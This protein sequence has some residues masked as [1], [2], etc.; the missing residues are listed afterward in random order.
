MLWYCS[1]TNE[2]M[3]IQT[4]KRFSNSCFPAVLLLT[5]Q[6]PTVFSFGKT[7]SVMT[8][9]SAIV[10]IML[11]QVPRM[12]SVHKHHLLGKDQLPL[13][14]LVHLFA[15]TVGCKPGAGLFGQQGLFKWERFLSMSRGCE[16]SARSWAAPRR[17]GANTVTQAEPR[18][19]EHWP[20]GLLV[21]LRQSAWY[22]LGQPDFLFPKHSRL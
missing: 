15:V 1:L 20:A 22:T 16:L 21:R 6:L 2:L 17:A 11:C 8:N 4:F 7:D 13:Q 3:A 19:A 14:Q 9:T 12:G 18:C 10:G 5:I